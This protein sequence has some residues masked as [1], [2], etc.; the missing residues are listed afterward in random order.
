MWPRPLNHLN[1]AHSLLILTLSITALIVVLPLFL[2]TLEK[3]K[4]AT[5]NANGSVGISFLICWQCLKKSTHHITWYNKRTNNCD[6]SAGETSE[7]W[8]LRPQACYR[9]LTRTCFHLEK[10]NDADC[11]EET[12]TPLRHSNT[13]WCPSNSRRKQVN[14]KASNSGSRLRTSLC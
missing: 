2:F 7:A 10:N 8:L 3:K 14:T 4:P 12:S 9:V 11:T 6:C 5:A 13:W 1:A